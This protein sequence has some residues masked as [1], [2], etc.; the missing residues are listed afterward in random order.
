MN[1]EAT[2]I[3]ETSGVPKKRAPRCRE[4]RFKVVNGCTKMPKRH[5][6]RPKLPHCRSKF[7]STPTIHFESEL[8]A[9]VICVIGSPD[10]R[11]QRLKELGSGRGGVVIDVR[12]WAKSCTSC[13]CLF[14]SNCFERISISKII[15][16]VLF[17]YKFQYIYI[18]KYVH[19]F[20]FHMPY[21]S[22]IHLSSISWL[23]SK[24]HV[25]FSHH[26]DASVPSC[27]QACFME[28]AHLEAWQRFK[29]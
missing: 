26:M 1:F 10:H 15:S 4:Q 9:R 14:S 21:G 5:L 16:H 24:K 3:G 8:A 27:V 20:I 17:L 7:S 29:K 28:P 23:Y 25:I 12:I 6:E 11:R 18:Y 19:K 22:T 13:F 2:K